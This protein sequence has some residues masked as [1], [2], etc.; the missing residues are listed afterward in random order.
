MTTTTQ[1]K[2]ATEAAQDE[3]SW[4]EHV[5][6][7]YGEYHGRWFHEGVA[8]SFNREWN[9]TV[10][11]MLAKHCPDLGEPDQKDNLGYDELWSWNKTRFSDGDNPERNPDE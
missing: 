1:L 2:A 4:D 11:S 3:A 10:C 5:A 8:I 9:M 6:R 7:Y